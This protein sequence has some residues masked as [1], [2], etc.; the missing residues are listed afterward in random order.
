MGSKKNILENLLHSMLCQ[1]GHGERNKEKKVDSKRIWYIIQDILLRQ[2][3]IAG[4][5]QITTMKENCFLMSLKAVDVSIDRRSLTR[6]NAYLFRQQ[7][8]HSFAFKM[9]VMYCNITVQLK[10]TCL[11]IKLRINMNS[12]LNKVYGERLCFWSE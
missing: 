1:I 12:V 10:Q 4:Q 6:S 7:L 2:I 5:P 11:Q 8:S 3:S 9:K